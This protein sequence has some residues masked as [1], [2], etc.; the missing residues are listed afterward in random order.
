MALSNSAGSTHSVNLMN[1]LE[2]A[3]VRPTDADLASPQQRQS[4][5]STRATERLKR[6]FAALFCASS[7]EFAGEFR[8]GQHADGA[9]IR[10]VAAVRRRD[11]GVA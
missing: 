6:Q 4:I 5:Q 10:G 2:C 7:A 11:R 9:L 3:A 1:D 8:L